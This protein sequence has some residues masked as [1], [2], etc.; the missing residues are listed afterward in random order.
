[1]NNRPVPEDFA[2]IFPTKPLSNCL[3]GVKVPAKIPRS[4]FL[5][6]GKIPI[7]SQESDFIN[8]YWD[9][10]ADAVRVDDPVVVFGDHTQVLK[11]IDFDFVVGADG[12]KILK[13]KDFLDA[14]FLKYFLEA[15]PIASLGY[16]R[17]YR[18][19]SGMDIPLP[20]LDEQRRI[21]AVLDQA[22]S[23]L[24][25]ARAHAEANIGSARELFGQFLETTV[26]SNDSDWKQLPLNSLG[27]TQT[28]STPKTSEAENYGDFVPFI[29]PGDFKP[30][31]AIDLKNQGLSE[32]GA[33]KART[34]PA[35]SA[36]MV[37]IGA[38]IGKSGFTETRITTNQ[39]I[40]SVTPR[41]GVSG[42]F[43]YYQFI[44]SGFQREV[45]HRS[46]QAT[47]RIINKSKWSEI[48][49]GIPSDIA[50]Q[51]QIVQTLRDMRHHTEQLVSQY[52]QKLADIANLR[53]SLLQKAFSGELT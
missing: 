34:V 40:N 41:E 47:L 44:S 8:G 22:F 30:D 19:I 15:N 33:R 51:L 36:L 39:Q 1:M 20:P 3:E 10:E 24:D 37:C 53:Q 29:K 13:P 50:T 12:V 27:A 31:G 48:E 11:L 4:S 23:A 42:E 43:L 9:H 18:H 7:I 16:A 45:L 35:G 38:T 52:K 14:A 25:R 2:A 32:V 6:D 17:H 5:N 49:V 21:V 46:G 28:G 26:A